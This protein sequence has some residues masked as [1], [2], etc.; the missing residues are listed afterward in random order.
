M[1][2]CWESLECNLSHTDLAPSNQVEANGRWKLSNQS[3]AK[4]WWKLSIQSGWSQREMEATWCPSSLQDWYWSLRLHIV[5]ENLPELGGLWKGDSSPKMPFEDEDK[6]QN[7]RFENE[8]EKV[9]V[10]LFFK[11]CVEHWNIEPIRTGN[12]NWT[13]ASCSALYFYLTRVPVSN[14]VFNS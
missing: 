3:E 13:L 7:N 9:E 6:V 8:R 1:N 5:Q 10:H 14:Q 12:S 2:T 11:W 4:G